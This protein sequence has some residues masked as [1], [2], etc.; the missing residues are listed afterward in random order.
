[1]IETYVVLCYNSLGDTM[2]QYDAVLF[3]LDGTLS[4]S[5]EGVRKC[6][7]LTLKQ[8]GKPIPDLSDFSVFIGPPLDRTFAVLCGLGRE[9]SLDALPIYRDF[10][11]IYGTPMNRL[12]DGMGEVLH[13]L[14][15]AGLKLAVC[16]SKN[17]R[18]A[19]D[20][21]DLLG[22][23]DS[24]DAIC[25]SLDSGARKEKV[26]LIPY[27]LESLGGIDPHRAVMI[28]DTHFD[29][30][31]AVACGLSFIGVTYGYGTVETMRQAGAERFTDTPEGI[32]G[33]II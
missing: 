22:I 16:T 31:G 18:L 4:A 6:I 10:Y 32:L 2:K 1:M 7:E 11:D 29:V 15:R 23:T 30:A 21:T 33:Y 5:A 3:D 25:G 14:R 9:G 8:M 24:F 27:A 17:E 13:T 20:V 12:Y 26:D 28:G 19:R